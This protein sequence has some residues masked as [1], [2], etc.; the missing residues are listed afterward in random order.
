[1]ANADAKKQEFIFSSA[2][3]HLAPWHHKVV[4]LR[5]YTTQAVHDVHEELDYVYVDARHDFW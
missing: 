4:Y 5:N 3:K 2:K 1:M